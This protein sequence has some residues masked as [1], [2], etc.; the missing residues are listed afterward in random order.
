MLKIILTFLVIM[1]LLTPFTTSAQENPIIIIVLDCSRSMQEEIQGRNKF[2]TAKQIIKNLVE[3]TEDFDYGLITFGKN[4]KNNP[5]DIELTIIPS[6]ENNRQILA[7]LERIHP[8][9]LSPIGGAL[10]FAASVLKNGSKNYVLLL[11]DGIEN[12]GGNPVRS[13]KNLLQKKK[14]IKLHTVGFDTTASKVLLLNNIAE[15]GNGSYVY[16]GNYEVLYQSFEI[17]PSAFEN[18]DMNMISQKETGHIS[19]KIF[20]ERDGGF[21]AYGSEINIIDKNNEVIKKQFLWKGIIENIKPGTYTI[22]AKHADS[23]KQKEINV[24][25]NTISYESFIF[26]TK[27]GG[28]LFKNYVRGSIDI[29]AYGTI[30]RVMHENGETVYTGN[31]WEGTIQNLPIGEY[32]IN[33]HNSDF[34]F[35]E[36]VIVNEGEISE[37]LFEFP[38][39]TGQINYEC[40]LDSAKQKPAYGIIFRIYRTITRELV[41][42][43][44]NRRYRGT[45]NPI[46]EGKYIIS[47]QLFGKAV[48]E[49]ITVA[50]DITTP[51]NLIFNIKQMRLVYQCYRTSKNDPAN[52]A[53]ISIIDEDG[54]EVEKTQGWRGNFTLPVGNYDV[55]V[56]YQNREKMQRISLLPSITNIY[57]LKIYILE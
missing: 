45:T 54:N 2:Q 42:E 15:A 48:N 9:G 35:T 1:L 41:F 11:S 32:K 40:F 47:G 5:N 57:P 46:P 13:S 53:Q 6:P 25:P 7:E 43:D 14:I 51:Y 12:G 52:G 49:E 18:Q 24:Y 4:E 3:N 39:R 30:T 20:L 34:T 31:K 37:V 17:P 27:V 33:A 50:P 38:L 36:N 23:L 44:E 29:Y 26:H 16:F 21:P 10:D 28:I 56:N 22:T 55:I 19:Y 8:K